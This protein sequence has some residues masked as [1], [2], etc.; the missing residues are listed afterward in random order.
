MDLAGPNASTGD[1]RKF[2]KIGLAFDRQEAKLAIA[3]RHIQE[4]EAQVE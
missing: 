2:Q 3:D 4:L 1:C